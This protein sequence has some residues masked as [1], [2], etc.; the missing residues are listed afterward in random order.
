M[1][2]MPPYDFRF[3]TAQLIPA[4]TSLVSPEPL[5]PRTR[6]STSFTDG[7]LPPEY[8]API[9]AAGPPLPPTIPAT[10]VPWP[11]GS[12]ATVGSVETK[13]T[14]ATTRVPSAWCDAMPESS[15]ATVMPLPL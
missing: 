7:A 9:D 3:C 14:R 12:P 8:G 6:T 4:I 5:L 13:L 15:T 1:M 11:N 2:R 10:C